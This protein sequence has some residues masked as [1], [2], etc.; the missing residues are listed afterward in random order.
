MKMNENDTY[1]KRT[2]WILK[3][4]CLWSDKFNVFGCFNFLIWSHYKQWNGQY[5]DALESDRH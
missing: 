2:K 4:K 1:I 5:M 3:G